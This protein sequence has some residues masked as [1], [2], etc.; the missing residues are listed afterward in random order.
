MR[1]ALVGTIVATAAAAVAAT[2]A[3]ADVKAGVD[4][5][6]QGDYARAITEWRPLAAAGDADAQF[7]LGQ[8]YKLGRGVP[9]DLPIAMDW[10]RK[11]SAQGHPRAA[12]NLGLLLF[13]QGKREEAL[14][15]IRKSAERGEARAQYILGTAM[16]NGD[17]V[18]K[19]WV[20]AYALMTRAAASGLTQAQN[21]LTTMDKY[22]ATDDR[23]KGLALAAKM[24]NAEKS[25]TAMAVATPQPVASP[26]PVKVVPVKPAAAPVQPRAVASAS[27]S[28]PPPPRAAVSPP[29]KPVSEDPPPKTQASSGDGPRGRPAP[30]PPQH[31]AAKPPPPVKVAQAPPGREA[32]AAPPSGAKPAKPPGQPPGSEIATAKPP[33]SG[34]WRVQLGAFKE[35]PRAKALWQNATSKVPGLSSYK[36]YLIAGGDVTR[37]QAGPLGSQADAAKLCGKLQ[38]SG[39][40]CL[41]KQ[42]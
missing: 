21:S 1:A 31:V 13:Q 24:E 38:A 5:W 9:V 33:P 28:A 37:V 32:S 16:F 34:S 4:A 30:P 39:Y 3:A 23:Q 25:G 2:P 15:F 29:P 6:Q 20:T 27:G 36:L 35:A 41:I 17:I 8:A 12:D 40:S 11:A 22:I 7:N 18:A 26:A 42:N 19:D 14:P 10:F